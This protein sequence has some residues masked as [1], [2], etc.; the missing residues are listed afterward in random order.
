[1]YETTK[2]QDH[3]TQATG[4]ERLVITGSLFSQDAKDIL[5]GEALA[6]LQALCEKFASPLEALLQAR[7]QKQQEFDNGAL[8]DFRHD[9]ATIR[10]DKSWKVAAI[11]APLTDRRVEITGPV[12]RKMVINALNSG[13]NVFMCCFEDATSPTWENMVNG[14]INMRDANLGTISYHEPAN[15]KHYQLV[16][17]PATLIHRPRGLHLKEAHILFDGHPMPASLMDFGLYFFH[18][19]QSRKERGQGVYFYLPKLESMEEAAWWESVF[20]FSENYV[21]AETGTIRATVL[22]ETLPAVF[23]MEEI[24]YAMRKHIVG[25]NCGRWDY[26][27]SY[28]KTLK[29]H[30]DRILP[31]RHAIG[32]DQP[33]LEAYSKRLIQTCHRRGALAIGGMSAFIPSKDPEEM[34]RVTQKVIEDKRREA[35]N[36]HDGT[37]VAHPHLVTLARTIFD[38]YLAGATNQRH[39]IPDGSF[40][41]EVLLRPSQGPKDEAGVRKNIRI[42]VLY[43][44]AWLRGIGCVPIYG[45]MEDAATAEISRANI[46]QWLKHEVSLDD[47]RPFTTALFRQWLN[48]EVK[49][50][51]TSAGADGNRKFDEASEL[52]FT[53]STDAHFADFL[54]IPCYAKLE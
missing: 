47:G 21:G 30:T 48:E 22:I 4:H 32:M 46:W 3:L 1:M 28:I 37:W 6:F 26:I 39:F 41:S 38:E 45:L 53:L 36:G 12:D 19:Y 18:N 20:D 10:N 7:K 27:F 50:M 17:K 49:D 35:T 44:E 9:T 16:D 2:N 52:F 51:K 33:F 15:G 13:A 34:A 8:P 24:L 54:T 29:N 42:A 31:D 43:M 23:Q 25:M 14:Q 5:S 40:N 11:P